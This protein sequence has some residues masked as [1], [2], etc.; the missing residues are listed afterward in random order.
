MNLDESVLFDSS[1]LFDPNEAYKLCDGLTEEEKEDAAFW[2]KYMRGIMLL[3]SPPGQGKDMFLH[4]LAYKAKRYWGRTIILDTRPRPLFGKYVPFSEPF[5]VEQLD[6][7]NEVAKGHVKSEEESAELAVNRLLRIL[8]LP[9]NMGNLEVL[10]REVDLLPDPY[11]HTQLLPD[12]KYEQI[13]SQVEL[14]SNIVD[15]LRSSAVR[16]LLV[17]G[18]FTKPYVAPDGRWISSRGEVF[19]RKSVM[20]LNEFGSRYMYKRDPNQP[21]KKTLIKFFSFWRHLHTLIIGVGTDRD[22]IDPSC[23]PDVTC[24]ARCERALV[25][26]K[27]GK[28]MERLKF[29]VTLYP[30][31]FIAAT[32]ELMMVDNDSGPDVIIIDGDKSRECLNGKAWKDLFNTAA[33]VGF[34]PPKSMRQRMQ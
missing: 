8:A 29:R 18:A 11:S 7:I 20:G 2:K 19:M 1:P 21:I 3:M 33:P 31:R 12:K 15:K 26:D 13:L 22:K 10:N 30:M 24:E 25:L 4:M 23:F 5:M 14:P 6:R 9:T 34:E 27:R 17:C 16:G 32:G 28:P